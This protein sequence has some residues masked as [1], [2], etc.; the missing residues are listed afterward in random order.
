MRRRPLFGLAALA[1][2]TTLSVTACSASSDDGARDTAATNPTASAVASSADDGAAVESAALTADNFAARLADAQKAKKSVQLAMTTTAAGQKVS[3]EGK[4][5]LAGSEVA[6][7]ETVTIPGMS[8]LT[9]RAVD[10]VVYVNLGSLSKDKWIKVDPSDTSNPLASQFG[11]LL[12]GADPTQQIEG[13]K[14]AVASVEKSG[15][16]ETIDGVQAQKY[17]VTVDTAKLGDALKN[18]LGTSGA[19]LPKTLTYTYWVDRD[20]LV[21][22]VEADVSG[23]KI[24]MTFSH[25]GEPVTIT[26]PPKNDILSG[27]LEDLTAL[28]S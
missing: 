13:L 4:V 22:K 17:V 14:G 2:G 19:S 28:A 9:V 12:D 20:D 3:V 5:D 1:V 8:D 18:Q 16:L 21:R 10:G 23:A 15:A 25:W 7:D 27:G 24:D 26:A 11:G 6:M